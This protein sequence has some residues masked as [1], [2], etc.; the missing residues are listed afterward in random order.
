MPRFVVRRFYERTPHFQRQNSPGDIVSTGA[1]LAATAQL[2]FSAKSRPSERF[3]PEFAVL[4]ACCR[5]ANKADLIHCLTP[6]LDWQILLDLAEHHRLIPALQAGLAL[7]KQAAPAALRDRARTHAWRAMRFTAE[8]T[9]IAAHF[10]ERGIDFLAYKGPALAQLL[11]GDVT[12]RQFGDL[13]LLVRPPDVARARAA[14]VEL[15]F[16]SQLSLSPRQQQFY[17]RT[18]YELAFGIAAQPHLLELQWQVVPRFYS[19]AF[20][21]D[22]LFARSIRIQLDHVSLRTPRPE[23]LMLLLCVHAAKHEWSQLGMLRDISALAQLD[24]DWEWIADQARRLGI[25]KIVNVSLLCATQLLGLVLPKITELGTRGFDASKVVAA[26]IDN[27]RQN[28]QPQTES[29]PYF[30]RQAQL[31]ER[32]RDRARFAWRLATTPSLAEWQMIRLP[33]ALF[34]LYRGVRIGRLLKRFARN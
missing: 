31:R 32:W 4:L 8:L 34:P 15:G 3:E 22:A 10:G 1:L 6:S 16:T 18:G 19:V 27:L 23:D 17:L 30:R 2:K 13:D 29:I 20:E 25:A 14:L 7:A 12:M 9:R 5:T 21:T 28:R 26:V 33:D 24:L 11:Y